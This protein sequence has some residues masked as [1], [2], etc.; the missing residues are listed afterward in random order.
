[1]D[2]DE[3]MFEEFA[4]E[5]D[6]GPHVDALPRELKPSD[7]L[8][9]RTV[10]ALRDA[11]ILGRRRFLSR[12]W[13][14]GVAAAAIALFTSGLAL[15]QWMAQR[16]AAHMMVA[17]QNANLQQTAALVE[18]AGNAYVQAMASLAESQQ[19][20]SSADALY[21]RETALTILHQAANQMVRIAPN[22]PVA[23]NILQGL[24]QANTHPSDRRKGRR[25]I[26]F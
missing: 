25:V 10:R 26:W 23:V 20:R 15:G 18:K 8:E 12:A 6:L 21:A 24:D 11:G 9:E 5:W 1:M 3:N 16:N 17:Q 22:D 4:D 19:P 2:R 14:A 7:L 13:M